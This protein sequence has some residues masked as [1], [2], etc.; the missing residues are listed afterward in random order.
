MPRVKGNRTYARVTQATLNGQSHVNDRSYH[1]GYDGLSRLKASQ[2]GRLNGGKT[3][4]L[5][6]EAVALARRS[7]WRLDSLGN[8]VGDPNATPPVAGL[9]SAGYVGAVL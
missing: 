3:D 8:W 4:I 2:L 5:D 1:Y 9:A 6:D 7:V